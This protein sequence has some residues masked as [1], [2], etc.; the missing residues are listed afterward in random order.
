ME[1]GTLVLEVEAAGPAH[2]PAGGLGARGQRVTYPGQYIAASVGDKGGPGIV[3]WPRLDDDP[4]AQVRSDR[5]VH[6]A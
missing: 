2:T 4:L 3:E 5:D 1:G 6:G